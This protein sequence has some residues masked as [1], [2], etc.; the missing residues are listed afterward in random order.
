MRTKNERIIP[1]PDDSQLAAR[2][3]GAIPGYWSDVSGTLSAPE[4]DLRSGR[5]S[6]NTGYR[7]HRFPG[8][9]EM[10]GRLVDD[11]LIEPEFNA[12]L[13]EGKWPGFISFDETG[14]RS[15]SKF[16][17]AK[18]MASSFVERGYQGCFF[19]VSGDH[20]EYAH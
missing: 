7:Y 19:F 9:L 3:V 10:V 6:R 18:R 17:A 1:L 20:R 2:I 4:V 8:E 13:F 16:L 15:H 12:I 11:R 5:A 14:Y